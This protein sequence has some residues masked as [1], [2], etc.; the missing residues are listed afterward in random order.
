MKRLLDSRNAIEDKTGVNDLLKLLKEEIAAI[1]HGDLDRVVELFD[2]KESLL[3][4]LEAA[5][6]EIEAQ[7]K[8]ETAAAE[9]LR[10][11]L[12]E[13]NGLIHKDARL[14]ANM[15]EATHEIKAVITRIRKRHSLE[16]S[17][18]FDGEKQVNAVL[19]SQQLDQSM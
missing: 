16:G 12:K 19:F 3:K 4:K 15:V 13:L 17:Y 9:N 11:N 7:L 2:K 18:G 5:S 10:E 1:N 14:L 8:L 6:L